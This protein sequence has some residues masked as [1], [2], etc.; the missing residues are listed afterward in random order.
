MQGVTIQTSFLTQGLDDVDASGWNFGVVVERDGGRIQYIFTI[1]FLDLE[2][3]EFEG[4]AVLFK[5]RDGTTGTT[6]EGN[7]LALVV[8]NNVVN[9]WTRSACAFGC[10]ARF[11]I[12]GFAG[13]DAFQRAVSAF[14]DFAC[15]AKSQITEFIAV[16]LP[17]IVLY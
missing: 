15:N 2:A 8:A 1:F 12:L 13:F 17:R 3:K 10:F 9:D 14:D 7:F 6:G 5:V 11:I 16:L 4:F